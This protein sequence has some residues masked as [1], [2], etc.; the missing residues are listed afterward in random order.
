MTLS[1]TEPR[2]NVLKDCAICLEKGEYEK[3]FVPL[4]C[5]HC[6]HPGCIV[7]WLQKDP[8]WSCHCPLCRDGYVPKPVA[9]EEEGGGDDRDRGGG[10]RRRGERERL[11]R[12]IKQL[13]KTYD[14]L[15][16]CWWICYAIVSNRAH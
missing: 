11:R 10:G 12:S 15:K 3:D 9:I 2:L 5:G 6:F 14:N 13:R 4:R 16:L 8:P 7:K 1:F